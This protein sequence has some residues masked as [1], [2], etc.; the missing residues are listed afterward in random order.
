MLSASEFEKK[1]GRETARHL[2]GHPGSHTIVAGLSGGAD[3]VAL[4][5]ALK[6]CGYK[7]VA[8]HCNF[9]LRGEESMRDATHS[10]QVAARLGIE[11]RHIDFNVA[12]YMEQNRNTSTEMACRDLR[13]GW[14]ENLRR[15]LGASAVAV[16]H[17]SDD[18]AETL[19]LNLTRGTG[20]TGLRGMLPFRNQGK[21]L[22]PML[23]VSRAEIENY[24]RLKGF[25]HITDSTNLE[26]DYRRNRMRHIAL[27][28]LQQAAPGAMTGIASTM[29]ILAE[30]ELFFRQ[31]VEEKKKRYFTSPDTIDLVALK[32]NEP[33]AQLLIYE[34]FASEGLT[35]SQASD[36]IRGSHRSGLRFSLREG[37]LSLDRGR[38]ILVNGKQS[39]NFEVSDIF[40]IENH[41]IDDF[42]PHRTTDTAWFDHKIME[43]APLEIRYWQK[44][45]RMQPYGLSASKKVS[46]LFRDAHIPD[47]R[48]SSIPILVKGPDILWIPGVRQSAKFAINPSTQQ[49]IQVKL[50]IGNISGTEPTD[51]H[52]C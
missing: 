29:K 40:S 6:S 47:H 17:N 45:D 23:G 37:Y 7:C 46:D 27:P 50:K 49:F 43:G 31:A 36:I 25:S 22:R 15:E 41:P 52:G 24:L 21:I 30:T 33:S 51:N 14:F 9:H 1:V 39:R 8:A 4:L 35:A 28:A 5:V 18:N 34:W 11:F 38:L 48:K 13:Y 42:K 44:G 32:A 16:G 2:P 3:S 20:L 19:L 26:C 10:R 12:L